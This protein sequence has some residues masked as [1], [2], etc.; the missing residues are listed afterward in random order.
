AGCAK[1]L[2]VT[3]A[4][5]GAGSWGTALAFQLARAGHAVSLWAREP[6]TVREMIELRENRRYLPGFPLPPAITPTSNL[7]EATQAGEKIVVCAIPSHGV[8]EIMSAAAAHLRPGAIVVS[9]SKGIEEGSSRRMSEVI[10]EV[11]GG[12]DHIA[13]LSGPS[14]AKEV[15]SE[16]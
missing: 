16:M 14:F 12:P 4:V 10:A 7:A 3:T 11:T 15:A 1:R 2:A 13:V 8:R 6:G 5:I 9:A